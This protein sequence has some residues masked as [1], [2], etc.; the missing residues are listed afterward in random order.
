MKKSEPNLI[1]GYYN[2]LLAGKWRKVFCE[3]DEDGGTQSDFPF[4]LKFYKQLKLN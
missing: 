4:S 2:L 1:S 3:M